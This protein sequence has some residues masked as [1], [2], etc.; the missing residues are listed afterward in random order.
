MSSCGA[1]TGCS[2]HCGSGPPISTDRRGRGL[3]VWDADCTF[4]RR[5]ATR[6]YALTGDTFAWTTLQQADEGL[7]VERARL[8]QAIHLIEA[9]GRVVRGAE[10]IFTML[11]RGG[12]RRWPLW[13]VRS[14][15]LLGQAAECGYALVARHRRVADLTS[16]ALLGRVE[17]PETWQ[18][19]RRI[20]LRCMGLVFLTAFLSLGAQLPGLVGAEGLHPANLWL[21]SLAS[22]APDLGLFD[23]PTLQWWGG[24]GLL[25]ATWIVGAVAAICMVL[26]FLPLASA[27]L[28]WAGYL[29]LVTACGIFTGYQWDM[30]LL[31]AGVLAMLWSPPT[32]WLHGQSVRRPSAV[33][34]WLLVL[35]TIKL[36]VLSGWVKLASGDPAWA[37]GTAL[38]FHFWTQP[39]PWWPAWFANQL[40]TWLLQ[41][42]CDCLL[43][44]ECWVPWLLL[45]PRVPRT[46]A[47]IVLIAMQLG[48]AATGNYGFFNWLSIVLC[49]A[50]I[51]DAMLLL[52]WPRTIHHRFAV[53]LRR[54]APMWRRLA[55]GAACVFVLSISLPQ[56][57]LW[58][59]SSSSLATRW[60]TLWRPWHIASTYG[61]FATMTTTRPE[62]VIE[63]SAD[64]ITWA[65]YVFK[66]KPGPLD[67]APGLIQPFMPRLDWQL[68]FD[69]LAYERLHEAGLLTP[70]TAWRRFTGREVLPNLLRHLAQGSPE[71]LG[72]LES[73]P[74][75]TTPPAYLRWTLWHYRFTSEGP[76]W[77][78]REQL[79]SAPARRLSVSTRRTR[80]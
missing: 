14:I 51:D 33:V 8:E 15:P 63:S 18:L 64:G 49:L 24:D 77:W 36:M 53:G 13:C 44:V 20:F 2:S 21:G 42:M 17:I 3:V 4:C 6:L 73:S 19:T 5:W 62:L 34:R 38:Q 79:F 71:V 65:P 74:G 58:S 26:G 11:A 67:R 30:L 7:S 55:T 61:L 12:V 37:D 54:M 32:R 31:E 29:S 28:C 76:D 59:A 70:A 45:L 48:I 1:C 43:A 41:F 72:L 47:A 39:L 35:L 9:D 52:L 66:W 16:R 60:T 75:G 68:W 50:M 22:H 57:P 56:L 40:P 27:V 78:A 80:R 46:V 69:A 23:V 10:A 25:S